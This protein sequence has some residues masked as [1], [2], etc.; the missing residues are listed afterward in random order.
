M[1]N[2]VLPLGLQFRLVE[3]EIINCPNAENALPWESCAN[4]IHEGAT[5]L[6]EVVG[7]KVLAGDG[8]RLAEG[9][10]VVAAADVDQIFVVDGKVGREHGCGDFA[11]VCAVADKRVDKARALGWLWFM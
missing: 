11:A 1:L 4:T 5:G 10:Q 6:A 2:E 7:H 9:G 8:A 3:A